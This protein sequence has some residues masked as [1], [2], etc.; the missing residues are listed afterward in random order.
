MK[1]ITVDAGHG[2]ARDS[3]AF[4][5]GIAEKTL[6]LEVAKILQSKLISRGFNV[7]MTRESD[8]SLGSTTTADLQT[9]C[10]ISNNAKSDLFISI[11]H[12]AANGRAFGYEIYHATNSVNGSRVA[13]LVGKE[14]DKTQSKRYVGSGM[15]GG[16]RTGDYYVLR[17][18]HAPAILTEYLFMDNP[19]DMKKYNP[20]RE[21]QD[22][23]IAV[24]NYFGV[25]AKEETKKD[26][27]WAEKDYVE[28]NAKGIVIHER[29][30][31]DPITR[32]ELI[33]LLNRIVK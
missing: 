25:S 10:D 14:F 5:N 31:D 21:A 7:V 2:G 9:R 27:H 8:I 6:N 13:N 15:M 11:H 28:L 29:R 18:T 24:C 22:I 30:F 26:D 1:T 17:N 32:G 3:G 19:N 12:N 33:S 20:E 23:F 4:S 16:S